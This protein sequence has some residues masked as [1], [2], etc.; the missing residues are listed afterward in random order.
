MQEDLQKAYEWMPEELMR[1]LEEATRR[2]TR[3]NQ[4]VYLTSARPSAE[5]YIYLKGVVYA[6]LEGKKPPLEPGDIMKL[7][8]KMRW[9]SINSYWTE[10]E[11]IDEAYVEP[12][13]SYTIQ[14]IVYTGK[15]KWELI[16]EELR[17]WR[18]AIERFEKVTE[19]MAI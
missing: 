17:D 5:H 11:H 8:A 6:R 14:L 3:S 16:F 19:Y 18:F 12:D 13:K 7:S 10:D 2:A 1:A 4:V 9:R 15:G